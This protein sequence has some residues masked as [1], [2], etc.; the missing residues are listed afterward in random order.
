MIWEPT[1][2][3][4]TAVAPKSASLP[5]QILA[6]SQAWKKALGAEAVEPVLAKAV[7]ADV[8][9]KFQKCLTQLQAAPPTGGDPGVRFELAAAQAATADV[10]AMASDADHDWTLMPPGTKD[11]DGKTDW[12]APH[13]DD[14]FKLHALMAQRESI[15]SRYANKR[16]A[17]IGSWQKGDRNSSPFEDGSS[18]SV[19]EGTDLVFKAGKYDFAKHVQPLVVTAELE[20]SQWPINTETPV[21]KADVTTTERDVDVGKLEIG[22]AHV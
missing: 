17:H 11:C 10:R 7:P 4:C 12:S 6:A 21:I 1:G 5:V 8:Q 19:G 9:A 14:E 3:T 20:H 13:E 16:V 22:R 2:D 18:L 15:R